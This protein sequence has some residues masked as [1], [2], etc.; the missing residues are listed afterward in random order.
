MIEFVVKNRKFGDIDEKSREFLFDSI[1]MTK[2]DA[3]DTR[4]E[5]VMNYL[6]IASHLGYAVGRAGGFITN[7]YNVHTQEMFK[8]IEECSGYKQDDFKIFWQRDE[9][10]RIC[11]AEFIDL[12]LK[13]GYSVKIPFKVVEKS[14]RKTSKRGEYT[15]ENRLIPWGAIVLELLKVYKDTDFVMK[16]AE[17]GELNNVY[18]SLVPLFEALEDSFR[19]PVD[20]KVYISKREIDWGFGVDCNFKTG[21]GD[22]IVKVTVR[23]DTVQYY[24]TMRKVVD[25]IKYSQESLDG[26]CYYNKGSYDREDENICRDAKKLREHIAYFQ[27][28]GKEMY[29]GE[30]EEEKEERLDVM[31]TAWECL[32]RTLYIP[33]RLLS[34]LKEGAER[35][36]RGLEEKGEG[37]IEDVKISIELGS[38][39][40]YET[41]DADGNTV[42][43]DIA[44]ERCRSVVYSDVVKK[45]EK[46]ENIA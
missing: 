1:Q 35:F 45:N 32:Y 13:S 3:A 41:V 6:A 31:M 16:F 15:I 26:T 30:T 28:V 23:F 33:S 17:S 38:L 24:D 44:N 8:R 5:R 12:D 21:L 2:K 11:G 22:D 34:K 9:D 18:S 19:N 42:K 37:K 25:G 40:T 39:A 43:A 14:G 7:T 20:R 36:G 29:E 27:L 10:G 4:P 46:T